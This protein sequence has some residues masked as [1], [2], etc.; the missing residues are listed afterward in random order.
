MNYI[1]FQFF[2]IESVPDDVPDISEYSQQ[3]FR[4]GDRLKSGALRRHNSITYTKVN[5]DLKNIDRDLRKFV[6]YNSE[7]IETLS[8]DVTYGGESFVRVAIEAAF[9]LQAPNFNLTVETLTVIADAGLSL[10]VVVL[11]AD[12][13]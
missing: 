4:K 1:E 10:D 6:Q 12:Q 11:E 8:S 13:K 5:A 9:D 7:I 2:G 3:V